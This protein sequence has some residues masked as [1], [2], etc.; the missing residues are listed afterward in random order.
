MGYGY[1]N[2]KAFIPSYR[3]DILH[4]SDLAEDIAIAYGY[5]NFHSI[6]PNVATIAEEN[7]FEVFK[8][9][10]SELL[11]G[12][13]FIETSTYNLTNKELQCK[14]M[15]LHLELIE[16]ANSVS[17]DYTALRAWVVPSLF[18]VLANNKHHEYP[19]KIFTI[20]TI[21]KKNNNMETNVEENERFAAAIASEKT[22]YTEIRQVLDYLFRS[23]GLEY[24]VTEAEHNSFIQGR[25]GMVIV[26]G[27]KMAYIGEIAPAIIQNWELEMPITALELN[28][29]ELFGIIYR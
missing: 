15:N 8:R 29:S 13:G 21:F 27:K 6:I 5:E 23:L 2:K 12:L 22:D 17:L 25:V 14:R 28:L 3:A 18:E 26:N 24:E 10:I 4:Q 16:L 11:V 7:K 19:Q 1:K 9:K 20:G